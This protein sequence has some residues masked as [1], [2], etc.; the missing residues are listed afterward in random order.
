VLSARA[1]AAVLCYA[2][3]L[4]LR[5]T[6]DGN[7]S[8]AVDLYNAPLAPATTAAPPPSSSTAAPPPSTTASPPSPPLPPPP[9]PCNNDCGSCCCPGCHAING[10]CYACAAGS[11]SSHCSDHTQS[12]CSVCPSGF[13]CP[14]GATQPY[15]TELTLVAIIVSVVVVD[16]VLAC[17][18]FRTKRLSITDSKGWIFAALILGPL[19]WLCWWLSGRFYQHRQRALGN[20]TLEEPLLSGAASYAPTPTSTPAPPLAAAAPAKTTSVPTYL[21]PLVPLSM[22]PPLT[23][24]CVCGSAGASGCVYKIEYQGRDVAVKKFHEHMHDMLRRELKTLQLLAHPNIVRVLA[25][26]TDAA[27]QPL[28]FVM[29]Y[30]PLSLDAAMHRMTLQQALHVLSDAA[31]GLAVAHDACVI[32]SDI[33]PANVL[34]SD[35]YSSVKLADFG[36]AHAVTASLSTLSGGRGTLLYMAPELGDGLPLSSCTDIFSFGMMMWQVLHPGIQNPFGVLHNVIVRKLC[37]GERPDFTR[38]DAPPALKELVV[39][40]LAHDPTKRPASMW[41]V[42]RQLKAILQQLLDTSPPSTL[43]AL[44]SQPALAAP[45]SPLPLHLGTSLA[46]VPMTSDFAAFV[47][48]RVRREAAGVRISRIC[49]VQLS[50]ARMATHM[51]M[52]NRE[53][54]SRSS[55]PMLRPANPTDA[56]F[57]A[58][59]DK[60]KS[61]FERTCLGASPPCN[62]VFAWH[63]TPAQYVEAVCRDGP[64]AFRTTDGGFFGNGSYFALELEYATRYAKM[65]VRE[66]VM[67]QP[68]VPLCLNQAPSPSGEYPVIL[69]A[70]SV[71]SAYV[72]TPSRD[73]PADDPSQPAR[74]GFS[75]FYSPDPSCAV[76]LMPKYSAHFV[77]VKYSGRVHCVTGRPLPLDTDYQAAVEGVDASEWMHRSA[78]LSLLCMLV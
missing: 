74:W 10:T 15:V 24:S 40:C 69:F 27:S 4:T 66:P 64:R 19:V 13:F 59:L 29:E 44:L 14:E 33:K 11:Y 18:F 7:Y 76:A 48:A 51:D 77:P 43:A 49:R 37:N 60:L 45:T 54:S 61:A 36:L 31:L 25:I 2:C 63:G 17:I 46:D 9:P 32:H 5:A 68:R 70:V 57:T 52:F 41:D 67:S 30:V 1:R 39:R 47:R 38:A 71:A 21:L 3:F 53:I 12:S 56:A 73:Y 28:G 62:I 65:Q 20:D 75:K 78:C 50:S 23:P 8:N 22:L 16:V 42:Q 26:I 55:N 6:A 72:V 34:C 58:G 35:D